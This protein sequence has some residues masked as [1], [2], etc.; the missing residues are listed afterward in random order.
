MIRATY[1]VNPKVVECEGGVPIAEMYVRGE[2]TVRAGRVRVCINGDRFD[3]VF[4][5]DR[6]WP[7]VYTVEDAAESLK[8]V[9]TASDR[10]GGFFEVENT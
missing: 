4:S 5:G 6:P 8:Y 9:L 2:G 3:T 7:K 10:V 1:E